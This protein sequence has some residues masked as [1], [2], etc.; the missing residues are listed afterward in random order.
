[1]DILDKKKEK[2]TKILI[3]LTKQRKKLLRELKSNW[4]TFKKQRKQEP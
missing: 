1:M 2:K 3:K 4:A